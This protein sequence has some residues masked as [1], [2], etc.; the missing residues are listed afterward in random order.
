MV[1]FNCYLKKITFPTL[2]LASLV[3]AWY[4]RNRSKGIPPYRV[5]KGYDV[6]DVKSGKQKL[7]N[8]KVLMRLEG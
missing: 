7:T 5:L 2:T 8:M 3:T 6:L 4:C 1:D